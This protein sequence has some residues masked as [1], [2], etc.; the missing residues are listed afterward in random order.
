MNT[1][2]LLSVLALAL[3]STL[4]YS[5]SAAISLDR[6]RVIFPGSEKSVSLT[7]KNQNPELPYLAQGWLENEQGEKLDNSSP[8]A[9]VPPVQRIEPK[10]ESQVKI[11]A[12]AASEAFKQLPQ[13]RESLF[14]FNLREIPPKSDKPNVLQIAL[15][16]RIK[17]FYR[18]AALAEAAAQQQAVPFQEQLTLSKKGDK[19]QV[20]NPTP[21]YVTLIGASAKKGGEVV[22]GFEAMMVP[23]KGNATLGGSAAALGSTPV[24][25]YVNDYGGQPALTFRCTGTTC[26]V[27]ESKRDTQR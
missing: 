11:Q 25:V 18:P 16:T 24:L 10:A 21:Y 3:T 4:S 2:K 19:Y 6:T 12:L 1:K 5:A 13:D 8:L 14:Y 23:P 26:S 7:V 17:L 27:D 15:Q 22:K 20:N 9:V